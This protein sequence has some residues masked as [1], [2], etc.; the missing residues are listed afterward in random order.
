VAENGTQG[1]P[2]SKDRVVSGDLSGEVTFKLKPEKEPVMQKARE[3]MF[4][5]KRTAGTK[6]VRQENLTF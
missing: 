5:A 6:A 4:Q 3:R 2:I 1:E